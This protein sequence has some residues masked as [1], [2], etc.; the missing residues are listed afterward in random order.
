MIL[1]IIIYRETQV[2][3]ALQEKPA[4][5]DLRVSRENQGQKVS[6]DSRDQ[7]SVQILSHLFRRP[8]D[9]VFHECWIT[10]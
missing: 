6:E 7:W 10:C 8:D 4:P 3:S 2:L 9:S 1:T 5:W